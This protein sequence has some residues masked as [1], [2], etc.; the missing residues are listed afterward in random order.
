MIDF[1]KP[2]IWF[3]YGPGTSDDAMIEHLLRAGANGVRTCFSY[4][5][6]D[7]HADRARQVRRIAHAIGVD[8]AVIGDLQGEK[9]RLGTIR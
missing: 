3:T 8:V 7:V 4:G 5:T 9:C 1:T 2:Q 6:P